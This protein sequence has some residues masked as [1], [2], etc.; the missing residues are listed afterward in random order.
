M[1]LLAIFKGKLSRAC[2]EMIAD[3]RFM[4]L[5]VNRLERGG[6]CFQGTPYN[7]RCYRR[8]TPYYIVNPHIWGGVVVGYTHFIKKTAQNDPG[9]AP[10]HPN[11]TQ[12]DFEKRKPKMKC[13]FERACTA[14]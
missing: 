5:P 1:Y 13:R 7:C 10:K 11:Q 8:S 2:W 6:L 3:Y 9:T 4:P 12:N 14:L